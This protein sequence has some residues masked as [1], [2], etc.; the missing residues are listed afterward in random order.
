MQNKIHIH[1]FHRH[2]HHSYVHR[3]TVQLKSF[4]IPS[5]LLIIIYLLAP[6]GKQKLLC[7]NLN[8]N[9]PS[10][11]AAVCM[12]L[13]DFY[14]VCLAQPCRKSLVF[15]TVISMHNITY[16]NI[17]ISLYFSSGHNN[18]V[19]RHVCQVNASRKLCFSASPLTMHF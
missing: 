1:S 15:Y 11:Q 18:H 16:L 10:I 2:R 9:Q 5:P 12:H 19:F 14:V 3:L 8:F 17:I 13:R 4:Y 7:L 6:P